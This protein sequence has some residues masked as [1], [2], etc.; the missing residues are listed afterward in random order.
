V[1][2]ALAGMGT[3]RAWTAVPLALVLAWPAWCQ[4]NA[5]RTAVSPGEL[6]VLLGRT[7]RHVAIYALLLSAWLVIG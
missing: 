3:G 7:G 4:M 2:F 5:L 6:I 1:P